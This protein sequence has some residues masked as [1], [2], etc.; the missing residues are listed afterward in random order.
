[1]I[2]LNQ[3]HFNS[4]FGG[5]FLNIL[6]LVLSICFISCISVNA[7]SGVTKS[8]NSSNVNSPP[9]TARE[10]MQSD[11]SVDMQLVEDAIFNAAQK[12]IAVLPASSIIAITDIS[13]RDRSVAEYVIG[14]LTNILVD[15]FRIVDRGMM[16]SANKELEFQMSGDVDDN[17]VLSIGRMVGA[18]VIITGEINGNGNMR[19]L[20]LKV[21][22]IQTAVIITT[23]S[24]QM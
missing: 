6:Y 14:E 22:D 5:I 8:T 4:L 9:Q 12:I 1:M 13:S 18:N 20:R 21:L 15:Y 2:S 24:E 23:V 16:N 10:R 17:T 19:R 3:K 11:S 7:N